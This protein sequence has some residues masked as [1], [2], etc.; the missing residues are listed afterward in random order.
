MWIDVYP[1]WYTNFDSKKRW[2]V[3]FFLWNQ[4]INSF[5]SLRRM[6]LWCPIIKRMEIVMWIY[7]YPNWKR[8]FNS[9][10]GRKIC[11]SHETKASIHLYQWGEWI[12][13]AQSLK[14]KRLLCKSEFIQ[15]KN[16]LKSKNAKN[17]CFSYETKA[18]LLFIPMRRMHL[19]SN[20]EKKEDYFVNPC[21]SKS[22]NEH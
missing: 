8:I 7:V 2:E 6:N 16:E 22:T 17:R 15:L 4:S 1:S 3:K 19:W 10:N 12:C 11:F 5:I 9:K 18:S 14:E 13:G 21:L 20:H